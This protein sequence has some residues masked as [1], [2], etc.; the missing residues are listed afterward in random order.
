MAAY[1]DGDVQQWWPWWHSQVG[2]NNQWSPV[3]MVGSGDSEQ[4]S[5]MVVAVVAKTVKGDG[6]SN[7]HVDRRQET[8]KRPEE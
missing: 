6:D 7:Y 2:G 5:M 3:T 4:W 1:N 8:S